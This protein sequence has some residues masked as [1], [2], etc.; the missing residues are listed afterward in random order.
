[1]SGSY[2]TNSDPYQGLSK[3]EVSACST[4]GT[5]GGGISSSVSGACPKE[6]RYEPDF[7]G[8]THLTRKIA[9]GQSTSPDDRLPAQIFHHSGLANPW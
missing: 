9:V 8:G 6:E 7:D 2:F 5:T 4:P 1:M 3:P